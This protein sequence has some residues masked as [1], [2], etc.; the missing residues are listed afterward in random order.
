MNGALRADDRLATLPGGLAA[1][2][3]AWLGWVLLDVPGLLAGAAVVAAWLLAPPVFAL[4]LGQL[5]FAAVLPADASLTVI[6]VVEAPLLVLFLVDV[7]DRRAPLRTVGGGA[8]TLAAFAGL[9]VA[10]VHWL[11]R[12][13]HAAALLVCVAAVVGYALHRYTVVVFEFTDEF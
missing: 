12:L 5:L 11:A 4:A 2:T 6:A 1:V 9:A 3:A 7:A 13:R 10:G 8:V